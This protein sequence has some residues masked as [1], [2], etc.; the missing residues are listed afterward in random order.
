[1][2]K[3]KTN[4]VFVGNNETAPVY[5]EEKT[6]SPPPYEDRAVKYQGFYKK[7]IGSNSYELKP[8]TKLVIHQTI[9]GLATQSIYD[10]PAGKRL[11]ISSAIISHI[12]SGAGTNYFYITDG[13]S[14]AIPPQRIQFYYRFTANNIQNLIFFPNLELYNAIWVG[15]GN[16]TSDITFYGHIEDI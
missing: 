2:V 3:K 6:Q 10:I 7:T 9:T 1:M 8:Q 5:Q 11:I 4:V 15:N 12:Y 16:A 14:A 13:D